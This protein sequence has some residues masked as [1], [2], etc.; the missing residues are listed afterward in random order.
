MPLS[1]TSKV[2]DVGAGTGYYTFRI[3]DKIPRGTIYAVDIQ[4][5]FIRRLKERKATTAATNV[6]V[7]KG[8]RQSPNLHPASLDL[9]LMVDLYHDQ[10]GTASGRDRVCQSV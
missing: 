2:A 8:G 3:A 7:V 4:D 1:E 9:I 10:I 6:K 5:E